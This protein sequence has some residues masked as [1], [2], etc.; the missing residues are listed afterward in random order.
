[1]NGK[2]EVTR[3][4][5]HT[6]RDIARPHADI[7]QRKSVLAAEIIMRLDKDGLS[8]RAAHAETGIVATDSSRFRNADLSRFTFNRL[9]ASINMLGART[10]VAVK[11]QVPRAT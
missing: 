11:V 2:I 8:T 1:M 5:A 3:G 10:E 6:F 9:M 7:A 4:S